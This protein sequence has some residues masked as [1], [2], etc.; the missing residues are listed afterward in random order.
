MWPACTSISGKCLLV[1]G[2]MHGRRRTVWPLREVRPGSAERVCMQKCVR[3][4]ML[5][6]GLVA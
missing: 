2:C 3:V 1:V 5:D 4:C 6:G